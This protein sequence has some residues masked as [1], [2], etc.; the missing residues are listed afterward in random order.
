MRLKSLLVLN[1]PF[2]ENFD[3]SFDNY[4]NLTS[5][6]FFEIESNRMGKCKWRTVFL[7]NGGMT[8]GGIL[9]FETI[10]GMINDF[11]T[12]ARDQNRPIAFTYFIYECDNTI[13][14][15]I[16]TVIRRCQ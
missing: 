8:R 13:L 15:Q 7:G 1:E 9:Y 4:L 10:W 16:K 6:W 3:V 12:L 5:D 2:P 11:N 14:L